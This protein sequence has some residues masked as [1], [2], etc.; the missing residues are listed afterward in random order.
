MSEKPTEASVSIVINAGFCDAA[1]RT[2]IYKSKPTMKKTIPFRSRLFY[3]SFFGLVSFSILLFSN[4]LFHHLLIGK[5]I[6]LLSRFNMLSFFYIYFL[7]PFEINCMWV[8]LSIAKASSSV[9][10]EVLLSCVIFDII[11]IYMYREF[12]RKSACPV[13]AVFGNGWSIAP[14]G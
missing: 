1:D 5:L 11:C 3:F 6:F 14:A 13:R 4:C 9:F 2:P 12:L 8:F 7:F 10:A